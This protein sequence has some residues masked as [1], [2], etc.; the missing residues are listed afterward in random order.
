[1]KRILGRGFYR[2]RRLDKHL[3][4]GDWKPGMPRKPVV[5][6]QINNLDKLETER[7][8]ASFIR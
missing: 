7:R 2:A 4:Y 8:G 3:E 5:R 1:M 6:I